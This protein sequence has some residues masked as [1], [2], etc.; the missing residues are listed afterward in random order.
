MLVGK[1]G[2]AWAN[3]G[4]G[5]HYDDAS[6]QCCDAQNT[7]CGDAASPDISW[8]GIDEMAREVSGSTDDYGVALSIW[9]VCDGGKSMPMCRCFKLGK[10]SNAV[11]TGTF[12]TS[13]GAGVAQG[14]RPCLV[15]S[16]SRSA[17]GWHAR[18]TLQNEPVRDGGIATG[19]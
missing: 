18:T 6:E 14:E 3:A 9:F 2:E 12:L 11:H 7:R 15:L 10:R 5:G 1:D 16:W 8:C 13:H 19:K 17:G 4:A